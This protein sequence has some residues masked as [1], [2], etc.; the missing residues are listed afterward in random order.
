V[1][2]S[3]I[4]IYQEILLT[5]SP[6]FAV[7]V[8]TSPFIN[9]TQFGAFI[10]FGA[11]TVVGCL[12]VYFFVPETKGRTLEEMDELFGEVGF[13]QADLAR[14]EKIERDIGLIALLGGP[15]AAAAEHTSDSDE[16]KKGGAEHVTP[17]IPGEKTG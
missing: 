16:G 15:E 17:A 6:Q 14:K 1:H 2:R 4:P 3:S 5:P 11:I 9:A 8:S 10:F 7:A 12:W 13:A